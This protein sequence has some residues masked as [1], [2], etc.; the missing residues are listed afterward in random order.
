MEYFPVV[1]MFNAPH[2]KPVEMF[3]TLCLNQASDSP[4]LICEPYAGKPSN[5]GLSL[6]FSQLVVRCLGFDTRV[7]ILGHVQR[8]GTPSAFDRILVS[9]TH[10]PR[11]R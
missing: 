9:G 3:L 1:Y 7:T 4:Y 8:G 10:W 2:Q 6:C 11:L 5:N